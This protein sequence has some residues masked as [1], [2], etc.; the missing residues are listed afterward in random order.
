MERNIARFSKLGHQ[1]SCLNLT[2]HGIYKRGK[3][4]ERE[5]ERKKE[6]EYTRIYEKK[7]KNESEFSAKAFPR[8]RARAFFFRVFS[9]TL[10]C[11]NHQQIYTFSYP[12]THGTYVPRARADGTGALAE[13]HEIY[14]RGKYVREKMCVRTPD[15]RVITFLTRDLRF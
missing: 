15:T 11:I 2:F 9:T 4:G 6:S 1:S 3:K 7:K 8:R 13:R 10:R 12:N 14:D 5:K